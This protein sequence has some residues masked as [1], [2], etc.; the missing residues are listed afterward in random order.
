MTW[1]KTIGFIVIEFS[2][3][4]WSGLSHAKDPQIDASAISSAI[5]S[6]ICFE[7]QWYNVHFSTNQMLSATIAAADRGIL[8]RVDGMRQVEGKPW[9]ITFFTLQYAD[10]RWY[11]AQSESINASLSERFPQFKEYMRVFGPAR[12]QHLNVKIRT[13]PQSCSRRENVDQSSANSFVRNAVVRLL[14]QS[15]YA[16]GT[17]KSGA[18]DVLL[19]PSIHIGDPLTYVAIR[20]RKLVLTVTFTSPNATTSPNPKYAVAWIEDDAQELYIRIATS[21]DVSKVGLRY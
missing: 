21:K 1:P 6:F 3:L 8:V 13:D 16:G 20:G 4:T 11:V 2:L 12:A 7:K 9:D 10:S 17:V 14:A 5:N 15:K 18:T 19:V